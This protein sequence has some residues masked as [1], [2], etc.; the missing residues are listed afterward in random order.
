MLWGVQDCVYRLA[1][2][3]GNLQPFLSTRLVRVAQWL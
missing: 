2:Q 3:L 1:F